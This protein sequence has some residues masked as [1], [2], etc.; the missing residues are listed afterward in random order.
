MPLSAE[1]YRHQKFVVDFGPLASADIT[2]LRDI[3]IDLK[4]DVY[5]F[6]FLPDSAGLDAYFMRIVS[7][8]EE[9]VESQSYTR[10]ELVEDSYG[11]R[12]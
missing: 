3:Y 10:W 1:M 12:I 6:L 11:K 9:K 8:F 4:R 5:P 2:T 7:Q